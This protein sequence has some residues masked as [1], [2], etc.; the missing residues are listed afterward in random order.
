MA[1]L[2]PGSS[3]AGLYGSL[4]ATP[5]IEFQC[6]HGSKR[7]SCTPQIWD[8]SL[9]RRPSKGSRAKCFDVCLSSGLAFRCAVSFS[10]GAPSAP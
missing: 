5:C 6:Q 9:Q 7:A 4:P 3:S 1:L 8:F 10:S 2:F